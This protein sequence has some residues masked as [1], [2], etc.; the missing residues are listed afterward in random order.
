M[1]KAVP[2]EVRF[3]ALMVL[4]LITFS[5]AYRLPIRLPEAGASE[6]IGVHYLLPLIELVIWA[7]SAT[8]GRARSDL[9][10]FML[11]LPCYTVVLLVHFHLKLWA[12]IINPNNYD[13]SYWFADQALRPLVESCFT[14]RQML[15]PIASYEANLYMIGF[16][17]LFYTSFYYH[18]RQTPAAFRTLFLAILFTQGLGAVFYLI[19]PAIGPF[20]F[21]P[22]LNPHITEA[23]RFMLD[24]RHQIVSGG[25]HWLADHESG[26]LLTGLGAM[27]SLHV[28]TSFIFLWFATRHGRL[29]LPIY[30]PLF[31]FIVINSV[32]NRWHYLVDLPAGIALALMCIWLAHRCCSTSA[33]TSSSGASKTV[34]TRGVPTTTATA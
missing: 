21:E 33:S 11:A 6:F 2:V 14:L 13:Q 1:L 19:A 20:L 30:A 29:L 32:A 16:I 7:A 12:P 28:G 8:A 18:A 24:M 5:L 17:L 3:T 4:V 31:T 27:P 10:P 23:Q 9:R 15:L 22:G 25:A 26:V 34:P